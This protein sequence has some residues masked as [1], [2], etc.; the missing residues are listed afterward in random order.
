MIHLVSQEHSRQAEEILTC[1]LTRYCL[2]QTILPNV[3]F[4]KKMNYFFDSKQNTGLYLSPADKFTREGK[5]KRLSPEG[6]GCYYRVSRFTNNT[7]FTVTPFQNKA[8]LHQRKKKKNK[9]QKMHLVALSLFMF[10]W[11]SAC[12]VSSRKKTCVH[13]RVFHSLY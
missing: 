2:N 12:L 13:I 6:K 5:K 3:T 8:Q 10:Q 4:W 1:V 7:F 11:V 9:H